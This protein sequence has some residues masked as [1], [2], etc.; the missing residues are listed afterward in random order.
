MYLDDYDDKGPDEDQ[1]DYYM[2][3]TEREGSSEPED[4]ERRKE[5]EKRL[6]TKHSLQRGIHVVAH[7]QATF[8]PLK[9]G[10][11]RHKNAKKP[12]QVAAEVFSA[13][14][15]LHLENFLPLVLTA[16]EGM[17]NFTVPLKYTIVTGHVHSNTI[18]FSWSMKSQTDLPLMSFSAWENCICQLNSKVNMDLKIIVEEL[19]VT[20]LL[21]LCDKCRLCCSS[22]NLATTQAKAQ[23]H[24]ADQDSANYIGS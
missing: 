21:F 6:N 1:I 3:A 7:M 4:D 14:E 12:K 9:P 13:H 19:E 11:K 5:I 22:V 15:A 18:K 8:P 10:K 23:K 20:F 16:V 2:D 24:S 17:G